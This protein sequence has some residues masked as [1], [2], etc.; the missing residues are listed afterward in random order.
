MTSDI[1]EWCKNCVMC[2]TRK[3]P[4]PKNKAPLKQYMSYEPFERVALDIAGP[5]PRTRKGNK[6]L[7]VVTD[8]FSKWMEAYA[9]PNIEAATVTCR[10]VEQFICRFGVPS[11]IHT[12][13]GS[14]FESE[15][16][17]KTCEYLGIQKTRTSGYH[18]MSNGLV[19]R[20]NRTLEHMLSMF[21]NSHQNDWDTYL[22]MLTMAYRA[23]PH[24][25]TH[26]SP[27]CLLF[28]REIT[29]PVDVMFGKPAAEHVHYNTINEYVSNLQD[30]MEKVHAYARQRLRCA[31]KTQKS[32]YDKTLYGKPYSPGQ[33]VWLY[34]PVK[35]KGI[36]RK[37]AR[38]WTG[39]F[40]VVK[41]LND[42]TYLIQKSKTSKIVHFNRLKMYRGKPDL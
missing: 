12:D 35:K 15:L 42:V 30:S 23:T 19:E 3:V 34:T 29:L 4:V 20:L 21:V 11:E 16:F 10:F 8:Y 27:Y 13:Q 2:E 9:L 33:L 28:G 31:A 39:P 6:Y 24:S 17:T 26:V 32:T 1:E 18:P 7:L 40:T 37:L 22:P 41:S 25:S 38:P 14:Q 36:S 5:F